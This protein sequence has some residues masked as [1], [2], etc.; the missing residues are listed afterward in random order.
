MEMQDIE[1]IRSR[2]NEIK[3]ELAQECGTDEDFRTALIA[4]TQ[5][6]D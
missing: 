4:D 6:Y 5:G 3:G 2:T 1:K